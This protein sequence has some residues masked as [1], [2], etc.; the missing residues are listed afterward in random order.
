[1]AL[2]A[3]PPSQGGGGDMVGVQ[4]RR[5]VHGGRVVLVLEDV[6]QVQGAD[7]EPGVERPLFG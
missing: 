3:V 6:G 5:G 2:F 4:A 1:M 7:L